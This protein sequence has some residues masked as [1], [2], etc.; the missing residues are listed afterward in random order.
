MLKTIMV[1]LCFTLSALLN[2]STA[3]YLWGKE[4][5]YIAAGGYISAAVSFVGGVFAYLYWKTTRRN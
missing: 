1:L 3:S 2:I 4:L 5:Y